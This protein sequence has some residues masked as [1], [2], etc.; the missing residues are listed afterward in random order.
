MEAIFHVLPDLVPK[1]E[2]PEENVKLAGAVEPTTSLSPMKENIGGNRRSKRQAKHR[3][4]Y[5]NGQVGLSFS[6]IRPTYVNNMS[7]RGGGRSNCY[8]LETGEPSVFERELLKG[9]AP[10]NFL[11][12]SSKPVKKPSRKPAAVKT[13][14]PKPST[15]TPL[16]VHNRKLKSD[17]EVAVAKRALYLSQHIKVPKYLK[18]DI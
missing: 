7:C 13:E 3:L 5:I 1:M 11:Y 12:S 4:V 10:D 6:A 2:V 18:F 15:E 9:S 14:K 8:D 17:K 16:M